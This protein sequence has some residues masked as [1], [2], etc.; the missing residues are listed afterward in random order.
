MS[1]IVISNK[2]CFSYFVELLSFFSKR[3]YSF[4]LEFGLNEHPVVL[5]KIMYEPGSSVSSISH[6]LVY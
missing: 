3:R 4:S 5:G 2:W 6:Y 1:S